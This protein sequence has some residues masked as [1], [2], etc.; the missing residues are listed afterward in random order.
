MDDRP[1]IVV[2]EDE[3][4]QRDMLVAYLSRHQFRRIF[5]DWRISDLLNV[6]EH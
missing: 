5:S 6:S 2:I 3:V 4:T 1:Y